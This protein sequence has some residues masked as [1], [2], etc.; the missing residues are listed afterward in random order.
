[1]GRGVVW[2]GSERP[3]GQRAACESTGSAYGQGLGYE[4]SVR[5]IGKL[6]CDLF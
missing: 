4:A 1:M 6:E 3:C 5:R 2:R